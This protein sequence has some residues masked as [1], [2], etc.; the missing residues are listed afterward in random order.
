M[1]KKRKKPRV[2]DLNE[3]N[4]EIFEIWGIPAEPHEFLI[5]VE[6][7][8]EKYLNALATQEIRLGIL[9][10]NCVGYELS[11]DL[12]VFSRIREKLELGLDQN[13]DLI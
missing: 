3:R 11:S 13:G 9:A 1:N 5:D 2:K 12:E 4:S 10:W 7:R 8:I 6:K